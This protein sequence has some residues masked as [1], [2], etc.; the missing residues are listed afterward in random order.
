MAGLGALSTGGAA[1]E[2]G[3]ETC[4]VADCGSAVPASSAASLAAE[5]D[6]AGR[7]TVD[8]LISRGRALATGCPLCTST[9][10]VGAADGGMAGACTSIFGVNAATG[11]LGF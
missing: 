7:A 5:E 8:A 11:A 4:V 10:T 1:G 6:V 9:G 2:G 3:A